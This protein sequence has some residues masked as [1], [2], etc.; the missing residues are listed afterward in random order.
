[1]DG[2]DDA[3]VSKDLNSIVMSWNA[4]A[5]RIFG[6]SAEEMIGTSIRRLMPADKRDEEEHILARLRRGERIDHFETV[7]VSKTGQLLNVS[8][9]ISPIR[10]SA[11][12]VIGA[13]KIARDISERKRAEDKLKAA[14]LEAEEASRAKDELLATLSHELRT[15]LTPVLLSAT[16]LRDDAR[17]PLD[18]REQLAMMERNITLEAQ[19][20]DDLLDITSITRGK[21]HMRAQL[22][23][24]HVLIGLALEFVRDEARLKQ[25]A[26]ERELAAHRSGLLVD[27][28][29][30]QQV[31]WN[32]LSNAIKFTPRYAVKFTRAGGRISARTRDDNRGDGTNWL[33]I[34]VTD[35]GIGIEPAA[36]ERIFLPFEQLAADRRFGGLG[37][38]LAIAR[39]SV[40]LH[41]GRISAQSAG[42]NRGSTFVVEFPGPVA[43]PPVITQSA[44]RAPRGKEPASPNNLP[45]KQGRRLLVVEDHSPTLQVMAMLLTREGYQVVTATSIAEALAAADRDPFDL[46]ISDLGLP[47]GNGT[48]LME[49]LRD[50][51]GL[52]G[53]A[54]SGYGRD[55]DITRSRDSGFVAH[56]V[57]P[58]RVSELR[59]VLSSL[60]SAP[61][62]AAA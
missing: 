39:T 9:T 7:R 50:R 1:M 33:R 58:V 56:L 13:S 36:L 61:A 35:S 22:C 40:E 17:L 12:N 25:I 20:I 8:V 32:L 43:A 34:E 62:V 10:D 16:T 41:G 45:K 57:K 19:L 14:K 37:L 2:S 28:S 51:H 21:L 44:A 49:Q 29:R 53:V 3:I 11:G 24:A 18:A 4:G 15:P 55:A 48:Q 38:G 59:R 6:Y 30:F 5:E 26:I 27:P 47:D 54:L 31:M 42:T 52:R 46:V 23:D 60:D